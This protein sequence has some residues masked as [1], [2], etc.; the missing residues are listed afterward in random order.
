MQD[1]ESQHYAADGGPA[2]V[3]A[4]VI[5]QTYNTDISTVFKWA[6]RDIIPSEKIAGVRRFHFPSVRAALE[7]KDIKSL[8]YFD[9]DDFELGIF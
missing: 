8:M 4:D 6:A 1:N 7:G 9:D 2:Y 3:K 5:A